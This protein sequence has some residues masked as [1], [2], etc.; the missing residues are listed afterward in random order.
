[1]W[2]LTPGLILWVD[3]VWSF[4]LSWKI[5]W[6]VIGLSPTFFMAILDIV[7]CSLTSMTCYTH[8]WAFS[9][10]MSLA[11][12]IESIFVSIVW[13]YVMLITEW[14]HCLNGCTACACI[15]LSIISGWFSTYCHTYHIFYCSV[16]SSQLVTLTPQSLV[17][18]AIVDKCSCYC[19]DS[20]CSCILDCFHA[21]HTTAVLPSHIICISLSAMNRRP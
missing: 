12:F 19:I 18:D 21:L 3:L 2:T 20:H 7:P 4:V 17:S 6:L 15:C 9:Y 8:G 10:V 16:F 14:F 5:R 1:M 11:T 13:H